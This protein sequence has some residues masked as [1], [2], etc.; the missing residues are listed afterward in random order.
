MNGEQESVW[1]EQVM[2]WLKYYRGTCHRELTDRKRLIRISDVRTG[3]EPRHPEYKSRDK[4]CYSEWLRAW[5]TKD[6]E[7]QSRWGQVY[8]LL[9]VVQTGSGV[10]PAFCPM[11]TGGFSPGGKAV[12]S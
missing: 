8:S 12:R 11:R 6:S 7:F 2:A 3:I 1:N 9:H 4:S 10:H 5:T